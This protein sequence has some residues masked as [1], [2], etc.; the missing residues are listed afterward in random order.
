MV[1]I[2]HWL[3][4]SKIN[5]SQY[6]MSYYR[7]VYEYICWKEK[8]KDSKHNYNHTTDECNNGDSAQAF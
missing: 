3:R 2:M 4:Y 1:Y 7:Q 6:R 8:R 5:V